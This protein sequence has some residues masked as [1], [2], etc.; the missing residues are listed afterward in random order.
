[1]IIWL[2][3]TFN[4]TVAA[5]GQRQRRRALHHQRQQRER[6]ARRHQRSAQQIGEK[7]P[8]APQRMLR[9]PQKA[10]ALHLGRQEDVQPVHTRLGH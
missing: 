10:A 6:P 2:Q 8:R 1:M 4:D 9:T 7:P 5:V 3:G